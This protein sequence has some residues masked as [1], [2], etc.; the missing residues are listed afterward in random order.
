MI[1]LI[2]INRYVVQPQPPATKDTAP[3]TLYLSRELLKVST[4]LEQLRLSIVEL[5]ATVP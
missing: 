1:S 5:Q 4:E 3:L 2:E